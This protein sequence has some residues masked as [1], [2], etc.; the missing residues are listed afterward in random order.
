LFKDAVLSQSLPAAPKF[1]EPLPVTPSPAVLNFLALRKSASA[2]MLRAPAPNADQLSDLLRL[3]ARVPDHGK[4]A[5]WRFVILEGAAKDRFASELEVIAERAPDRD[6]RK[7]ALFKLKT[8]PMAVAVISR[9]IE[10]NIPEWEQRMSAGAVCMTLLIAAQAMG[11]GANWITDWYAFDAEVDALLGL[12]T[13]EKIAG[14]VYL[15]T[16]ADAPQERVRPDVAAITTRW[17]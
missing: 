8:P 16:L 17:G 10:G 1:G 9:H 11:F 6:K 7:G 13:G 3:A 4:L 14:Y 15:G 2:A 5:P 12:A